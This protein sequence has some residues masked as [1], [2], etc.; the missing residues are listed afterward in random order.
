ML[1]AQVWTSWV[2]VPLAAWVRLSPGTRK[3]SR[4]PVTLVAVPGGPAVKSTDTEVP[5][6]L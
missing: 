2:A 5:Y 1:F 6:A 3:A 4:P